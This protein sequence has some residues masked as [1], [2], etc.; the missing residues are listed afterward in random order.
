MNEVV[1][2]QGFLQ[3]AAANNLV[4]SAA[5]SDRAIAE[6]KAMVAVAQMRPRDEA[7]A[8]DK[9]L[10]AC[11]RPA[12]AESARYTYSR[13]GK[14]IT[15]P[16]IRLAEAIAQYWG[17][18]TWGWK[19]VGRGLG[20]SICRAYAWDIE[21]NV[22]READFIVPHYRDTSNGRKALKD[23]RDIYEMCANMAM[24]RV[25]A[26]LLNIIPADVVE[27]AEAACD[28]TLASSEPVTD[29]S[30]KKLLEAF[31]SYNV[32]RAMIEKRLGRSLDAMTSG[33]QVSLRRVFIGL[34]DGMGVV[35]DYFTIEE[36][37]KEEKKPTKG[38]AAVK[39]MLKPKAVEEQVAEQNQAAAQSTLEP[40]H[41]PD[42]HPLESQPTLPPLTAEEMDRLDAEMAAR[43][44]AEF[45]DQQVIPNFIRGESNA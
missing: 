43:E 22:R 32:T 17:N 19:E 39:Q 6:I 11:T 30:K 31:A 21:N 8:V 26:C 18:I 23:D 37:A 24:R 27:M 16:S 9:I 1:A 45:D 35:S 4:Q 13:G 29:D 28:A 20:S 40:E 41:L 2:Q 44:Q 34:K 15:G 38:A 3:T 42:P 10:N 12:L 5:E 33:Q 25:R 14:E 7:R 36:S